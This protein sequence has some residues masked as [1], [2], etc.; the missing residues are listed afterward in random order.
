MSRTEPPL[1]RIAILGGGHKAVDL[2]QTVK[3][4]DPTAQHLRV[5][6]VCDP[7]PESAAMQLARN[8]D[9][10]HIARSAENVLK[11]GDVDIVLDLRDVSHAGAGVLDLIP[12][13]ASLLDDRGMGLI[14][15]L[16]RAVAHEEE[17]FDIEHAELMDLRE[18]LE[19]FMEF[20]PIFIYM[21]DTDHRYRAINRS[22]LTTLDLNEDEVIGRTDGDIFP[23]SVARRIHDREEEVFKTH[24]TVVFDGVLPLKNNSRMY[25]SATLFPVMRSGQAIGLFGLVENTTEL[26]TSE[27]ELVQQRVKLTETRE[28]LQG[29]LENSQDIIFLTR[30]DGSLISFNTGAEQV[31]GYSRHEVMGQPIQ[32]LVDDGHRISDL[33]QTALAEGHAMAYEV[34]MKHK[35]GGTVIAN[36]SMTTIC[37]PDGRPSEV[38]GICRNITERLR[39]QENLIQS[40]RL[41]AIGKMAAGVA[42]EINNPLTIIE[43]I[44]GLITETIDESADSM[45]AGTR[46]MLLE[47]IEKLYFQTR[48]CT[49]ITHSLLGFARKS[50]GTPTEISI[51]DI[52]DEALSLLHPEAKRIN[53][54]V[55]KHFAPHLPP[56][57]TYPM[58][59][60]QILVNL[61]KNAIDAISER[62]PYD[63]KVEISASLVEHPSQGDD[64]WLALTI[65]DNGIGIPDEKIGQVF[66]LFYTSK[67]AGKGTGLGLSIVHNILHKLGGEIRVE[68]EFEKGSRFTLI[69]PTVQADLPA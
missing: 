66:D 29:I 52:V 55:T 15:N 4:L 60:E 23:A 61:L 42:H 53:L 22:A 32:T 64:M 48:R 18:R 28:Y 54:Q 59:L 19:S 12:P 9:V 47:W 65:A 27:K 7:D 49:T 2:L 45:E 30:V 20:S 6:G 17:A 37:T 51:H 11:H 63:A 25:F 8:L 36:I 21:K 50:S 62:D 24:E 38:V 1:S 41:A 33:L 31:L 40:E 58:L 46:Q 69:L 35:S 26:H 13:R 56:I 10:P 39:L 57:T 3:R 68:S 34:G 44:A 43:N 67:P 5:V 16:I 14:W